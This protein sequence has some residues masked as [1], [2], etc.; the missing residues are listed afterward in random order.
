MEHSLEC[1]S[2]DT[3]TNLSCCIPD[4]HSRK[5]SALVYL[6]PKVKI[7]GT[8][9]NVLPLMSRCHCGG[10]EMSGTVEHALSHGTFTVPV[11]LVR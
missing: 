6:L 10:L 8:F 3:T 9:E 5:V 4:T 1:L 2:Q 11:T 7:S